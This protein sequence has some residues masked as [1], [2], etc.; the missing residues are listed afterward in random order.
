VFNQYIG[1]DR[2]SVE[3]YKYYQEVKVRILFNLIRI[4]SGKISDMERL[5]FLVSSWQGLKSIH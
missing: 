2:P 1:I 3:R 5:D 4:Q